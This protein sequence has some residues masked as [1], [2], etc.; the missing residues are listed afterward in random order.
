MDDNFFFEQIARAIQTDTKSIQTAIRSKTASCKERFRVS[1][2][3]KG[4]TKY[5]RYSLCLVAL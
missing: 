1:G 5:V 2:H 3:A 4:L